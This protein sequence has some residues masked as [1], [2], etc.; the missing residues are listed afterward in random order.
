M[1]QYM[2]KNE[3]KVKYLLEHINEGKTADELNSDFEKWYQEECIV[4][5]FNDRVEALEKAKRKFSE[6]VIEHGN[7]YDYDQL[8]YWHYYDMHF[9]RSILFKDFVTLLQLQH[10]DISRT[11]DIRVDIYNRSMG[12]HLGSIKFDNMCEVPD[13]KEFN[14]LLI[15]YGEHRVA[16]YYTCKVNNYGPHY[17]YM[18]R[19][20][21]SDTPMPGVYSGNSDREYLRKIR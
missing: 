13:E 4:R 5:R 2:D 18:Y 6:F 12:G 15:K 10:A 9:D 19:I 17:K 16:T 20:L 21:I 3:E 1:E 11:K 14:S 7:E 8:D